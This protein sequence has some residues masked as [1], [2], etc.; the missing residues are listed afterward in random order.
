MARLKKISAQ[1]LS[2]FAGTYGLWEAIDYGTWFG[3]YLNLD[4]Q[5]KRRQWDSAQG[6]L[7]RER[8]P[9]LETCQAV[10]D[11]LTEAT[12]LF[13]DLKTQKAL[14]C[15]LQSLIESRKSKGP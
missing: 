1:E 12:E 2:D 9:S 11:T 15:R 6:I 7:I 10:R 5:A 8:G 14:E 4:R 13:E 3:L